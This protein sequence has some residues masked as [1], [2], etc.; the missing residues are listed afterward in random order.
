MFLPDSFASTPKSYGAGVLGFWLRC[1]E[2]EVERINN[3]HVEKESV[4]SIYVIET[5]A[6]G[7]AFGKISGVD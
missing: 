1:R 5:V 4:D 2:D 3:S 7:H 6:R